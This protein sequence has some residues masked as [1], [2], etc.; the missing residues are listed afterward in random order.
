[1]L[2][3]SRARLFA[4]WRKVFVE[5]LMIIEISNINIENSDY[6]FDFIFGII[7]HSK[8]MEAGEKNGFAEN[9]VF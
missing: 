9:A 4:L 7:A 1:M 2:T 8:K 6:I 5:F 3:T